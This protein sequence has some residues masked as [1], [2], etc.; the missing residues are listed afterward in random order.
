MIS[1]TLFLTLVF[2][3]AQQLGQDNTQRDWLKP[4]QKVAR[5]EN[6]AMC[7]DVDS[8]EK[9]SLFH[10]PKREGMEGL[11]RLATAI[12]RS[13][14]VVDGV[15]VFR[16][17]LDF[18][19]QRLHTPHEHAMSFLTSLEES[20]LNMLIAG[21][22]NLSLVP[23]SSR[24]NVRYAVASLGNGLGD[25]LLA[26]YPGRVGMRLVLEPTAVALSR[27]GDGDVSLNLVMG[28]GTVQV[29]DATHA[30]REPPPLGGPS[31]GALDFGEGAIWTLE[32]IVRQARVTFGQQ[33]WIDGR[34]ARSLYFV[35]G[36]FTLDRLV[37]V[38]G[39][40]TD[41]IEPRTV[42]NGFGTAS[43]SEAVSEFRTLAFGSR[44]DEKIG[45]GD[46][47]YGDVFGGLETSFEAIYG[48]RPPRHV[49]TFM[50]QYRI[51]P[52][53][54]VVVRGVMSLVFAAPGLASLPTDVK[55][56]TGRTIN[57]F[58]PHYL[59]LSFETVK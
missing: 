11:D 30:D 18:D 37:R 12:R 20:D 36:K 45:A 46:L 54:A 31:D 2:P 4:L 17:R 29:P 9:P 32:E 33:I 50:S 1:A 24:R 44:L 48:S 43:I 40:V 26:H 47:T 49:Q 6:I 53:D 19:D 38:I 28:S 25:S 8:I 16:R 14:T 10:Y 41:T 5:S 27:T 13:W 52:T 39:S 34:L 7:V 22:L 55:D 51:Q 56:N 58:V 15:Y 3:A 42:P 59:N 23:R 57:T 35:C 21:S